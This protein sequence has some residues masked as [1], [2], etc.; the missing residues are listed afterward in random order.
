MKILATIAGA[1]LV[2]GAL[3]ALCFALVGV[4]FKVLYLGFMIGWGLV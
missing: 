3:G 4:V 1:W 2:V